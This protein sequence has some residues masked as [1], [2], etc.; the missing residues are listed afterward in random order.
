LS[1]DC[2]HARL[3]SYIEPDTD[4]DLNLVLVDQAIPNSVI[5]LQL[6]ILALS[7][8]LIGIALINVFN[9][10][11]LA[12]Q[13]KLKAVGVLKTLGMTP[14]QVVTMVNATA[15]FLGLLATMVG[16]PLGL[17]FTSK[18]LYMMSISRGFGEVSVSLN[19]LYIFLVIP[20]IVTV[21]VMGSVVPGRKAARLSIVS[22]LRNE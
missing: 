3:K 22:V 12:V 7:G 8:V 17:V 19:I 6:A 10:S 9:T 14:A 4:S 1:P 2:Q 15:G 20:L 16:I 21:S 18:L 13:E 5:Y 11:M